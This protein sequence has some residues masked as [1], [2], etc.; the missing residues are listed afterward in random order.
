M[1]NQLLL[2]TPSINFFHLQ[3][4]SAVRL[5]GKTLDMH[6]LSAFVPLHIKDVSP[7]ASEKLANARNM[8]VCKDLREQTMTVRS[9]S[10]AASVFAFG[11]LSLG[12]STNTQMTLVEVAQQIYNED[13]AV[14]QSKNKDNVLM[15]ID[16][17]FQKHIHPGEFVVMFGYVWKR[18]FL[19]Y[20]R[21]MLILTSGPRLLYLKGDGQY[22]GSI[23]WSLTKPLK[24]TKVSQ[25]CVM[26][27]V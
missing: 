1:N 18:S 13:R 3:Y 5:P 16:Q 20:K 19:S 22:K 26:C 15:V 10:T 27:G 8:S 11:R 24:F 9:K 23:P 12:G 17:Q 2:P 4:W 21:R 25:W 6:Q 14:Q 7:S